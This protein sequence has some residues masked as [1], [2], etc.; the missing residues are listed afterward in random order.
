MTQ[1]VDDQILS[2]LLRGAEPAHPGE[3]VYTTGY[4]YVR[5]CQAALGAS[6]RSGA[7]SRPF[8]GSSEAIR[9]RAH[10][11]LL[12]LPDGIGLVSLRTLAPLVGHL[13]RR[14]R[15]NLLGIE[16]LAAAVHLEASVRLSAPS[17]R[18]E[19]A[20]HVEGRHVEV[21]AYRAE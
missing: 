2:A 14:H 12:E 4:W 18:L 1:L 15:L 13:R 16:A 3:A 11:K 20:L 17:P 21:V 9:E 7:L 10:R 19:E 5:L 8:A 6:E